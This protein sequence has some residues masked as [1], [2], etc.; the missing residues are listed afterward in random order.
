MINGKRR[1]CTVRVRT[2]QV[3]A[4]GEKQIM[5]TTNKGQLSEREEVLYVLYEENLE[6]TGSGDLAD[7]RNLLKIEE[8]HARVTLKKSGGVSW[9]IRFEAGKQDRAEYESPDGGFEIGVETKDVTIKKEHEKT[10]L[11]LVYTLVIQKEKQAA[12][13]LEI[14]IVQ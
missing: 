14:E 10:S 8:A 5:E 11:L 9:K 12:C 6:E 1:E 13:R 7:V 2:E 4:A 3:N